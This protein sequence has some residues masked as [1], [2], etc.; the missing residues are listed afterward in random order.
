MHVKDPGALR[1]RRR[2]L[3]LTQ[4][5]V[6]ALVGA[7]QQY[8]SLLESGKD[9]DCSERLVLRLCRWLEVERDDFFEDRGG[10]PMPGAATGATRT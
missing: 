7:T 1:R 9:R 6:A 3:G 4:Q 2:E 10:D 8:I 5:Q